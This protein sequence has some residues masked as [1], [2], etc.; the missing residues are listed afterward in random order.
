MRLH[1]SAPQPATPPVA[2]HD[3]ALNDLRFI[4]ETMERAGAFTAV[5]GWGGVLMGALALG[6]AVLAGQQTTAEQWLFVWIATAVLAVVVG[7]VAIVRKAYHAGMTLFS[8]PARQFALGFLPAVLAAALLTPALVSLDAHARLPG[9]WLLLYGAGVT[10][11]GAFSVR[12][13]PLM[14][15]CFM[16]LGALALFSPAGWGN[17][18]MAAGFGGLHIVVGAIIARRYGG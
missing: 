17:A 13:V 18:F 12:A 14:G 4:R 10:T 11:G 8:A 5:P 6:A 7:A 16:L 1:K 3:R 2:L 9:V 15:L